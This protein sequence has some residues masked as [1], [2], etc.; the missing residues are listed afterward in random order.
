MKIISMKQL[1]QKFASMRRA[2]ERGESYL[3]MY[4]SKPLAVIRPYEPKQD[5]HL[6]AP[7]K[8]EPLLSPEKPLNKLP[9]PKKIAIDVSKIPQLPASDEPLIPATT[10]RPLDKFGLKKIFT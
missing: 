3:L 9:E 8:E 10:T 2:L 7:Q 4:R 5:I 6:L 1:R